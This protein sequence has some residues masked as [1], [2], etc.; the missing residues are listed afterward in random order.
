MMME[1]VPSG[2]P[3]ERKAREAASVV[4]GLACRSVAS[5][6]LSKRELKMS[7]FFMNVQTVVP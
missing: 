1:M 5:P 2:P 6:R 3:E 4:A 7:A